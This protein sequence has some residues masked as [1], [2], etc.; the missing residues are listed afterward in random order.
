MSAIL[1]ALCG[2]LSLL[3]AKVKACIKYTY[4]A[5]LYCCACV[6][7]LNA[8]NTED[9]ILILRNDGIGDY[10]LFRNF[11]TEIAITYPKHTLYLI[12]SESY[13]D[14]ALK[15]DSNVI[16]HFIGLDEYAFNHSPCYALKILRI[17]T[18]K[19][20][21]ILI[22]PIF[23]RG[24]LNVFLSLCIKAKHKYAPEGDSNNLSP[25]LKK[26][27][28]K[29]FTLL[30]SK[31]AI[32]F[33]FE[34]N[35]E[36]F[37]HLLQKPLHTA[38]SLN[39][40]LLEQPFNLPK[41]YAVLF[42]G[43]S[44]AYR[45]YSIEHFYQIALHLALNFGLHLV[46]CGGK[47]D[48][49]RGTTLQS[50]IESSTSLKCVSNLTGETTLLELGGILYNGNLLVSNETSAAHLAT[51]LDT[52]IVI[53]VSNGNHLGRFIPYPQGLRDKY[54]P[55]FHPFIEENFDKYEKLS[56]AY[57]YKSTLDIDEISPKRVIELI[58]SIY[59]KEQQ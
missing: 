9:S 29:L 35:K 17:C 8:K 48:R 3:K 45:Q 4:Y 10:L 1:N 55:V 30:P 47:E 25:F 11:L 59:Q 16:A 13:K 53:V 12:C 19:R 32:L 20:Y 22:D 23:S 24:V 50:M 5:C 56:N 39:P 41:P 14:F 40:A 51:I 43:A 27:S 49:A 21:D 37:I 15:I 52:T 54:Y 26:Q 28:D 33:E 7:A 2:F 42:I 34:R 58:N 57:A 38:L 6:F 18:K 36:F 44:A 46:I 31:K